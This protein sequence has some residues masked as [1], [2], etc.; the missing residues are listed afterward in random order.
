MAAVVGL[1]GFGAVVLFGRPLL[2]L[3]VGDAYHD[4]FG[5][6]VWLSLGAVVQL[7][8]FPL[9]P[10]LLATGRPRA[11]L[12]ARAASV[13]LYGIALA[14]GLR[15]GLAGACAAFLAFQTTWAICLAVPAHLALREGSRP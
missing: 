5:V 11:V 9:E 4:A 10:G 8:A 6:W 2:S 1:A 15:L 7:A 12:A 14:L 13:L 3:T